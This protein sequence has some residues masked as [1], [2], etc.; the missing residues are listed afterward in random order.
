MILIKD[1]GLFGIEEVIQICCRLEHLSWAMLMSKYIRL[2]LKEVSIV[3]ILLQERLKYTL[4]HT[5]QNR[6]M[7]ILTL[8]LRD[9]CIGEA[10]VL[11]KAQTLG[12]LLVFF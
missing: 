9:E 7:H 4:N 2:V 5:N 8:S 10:I 6:M 3:I 1:G 12:M 11:Q